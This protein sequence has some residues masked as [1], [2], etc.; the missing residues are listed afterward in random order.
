MGD[1][2]D[3]DY[4][5][6]R[7]REYRDRDRDGG[8]GGDFRGGSGYDGHSRVGDRQAVPPGRVYV[9]DLPRDIRARELEDEMRRYGACSFSGSVAALGEFDSRED[10]GCNGRGTDTVVSSRSC[11]LAL[12]LCPHPR[13]P[14][15]QGAS[16]TLC[17]RRRPTVRAAAWPCAPSLVAGELFSDKG[18]AAVSHRFGVRSP[19]HPPPSPHPRRAVRVH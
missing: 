3:R 15:Q 11:A 14:C 5:G 9:G 19:P 2:G 4:R 13:A 18:N 10:G 7:D 6:D 1:R 8:R 12:S 16:A 17:C